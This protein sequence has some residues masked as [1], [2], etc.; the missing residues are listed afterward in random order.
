M[1]CSLRWAFAVGHEHA[2]GRQDFDVAIVGGGFAGSL[3]AMM[4]R[5][6]GKSVL[7]VERQ[8]HPRFVMGESSTPLANLLL[9][10][11]AL[12]HDLPRLLPLCKWGTWQAT[13]PSIGCGLKRGFSFYHHGPGGHPWAHD[14]ARSRELLVAASPSDAVADTH[15]YRPDFDAFLFREA[16]SMG[17]EALEETTLEAP[18]F[19]PAGVRV[20]GRGP[21]GSF[22]AHA[23]WL[24][25]A[26]GPRGYLHR[27]LGLGEVNPQGYPSTE[28]VFGHFADVERWEAVHAPVGTVPFQPDDAALHHVFDD[29]WT[30]ILRFNNGLTSAGFARRT[31][32]GRVTNAGEAWA[33]WLRRS[34]D[35]ARC[36]AHA[37]PTRPLAHIPRLSFRTSRA[38]GPGWL[39]L[40][41]AAG[42]VDPLLSM[43]FPLTLLGLVRI[44]EAWD[45]GGDMDLDSLGEETIR[46]LDAAFGMVGALYRAMPDFDV[47]RDLLLFYFTAAIWSETARRLGKP[48]RA[49]GFLLR[50]MPRF[51][52]GMREAVACAATGNGAQVRD[53]VRSVVEDLDL[54]G[55]LDE[56][57]RHRH[58]CDAGILMANAWRL[59][60]TPGEMQAMLARSGFA[61]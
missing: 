50:G 45:R 41:I 21:S 14:D 34:A 10:E 53:R 27:A 28:A 35:V 60:A 55:M 31:V 7:L 43:G 42:F 9:E 56:S 23:R 18:E 29:G 5:R 30:W 52:D 8:K 49:P 46:D 58:G 33:G 1:E 24:F 32:P 38:S 39:M 26:T 19:G 20:T 15:W 2:M 16:A 4:A 57:R 3:L 13:Y 61:G 47:F 36:F 48:G 22:K 12:R 40:P 59:D 11:I 6:R 54:A 37:V 25:D 17:A 44:G 51:A